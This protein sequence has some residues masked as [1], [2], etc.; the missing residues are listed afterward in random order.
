MILID[1]SALID[2]L[3]EPHRSL[4]TLR[5]LVSAGEEIALASLVFYDWLRGPRTRQQLKDQETI[6]PRERLIAFG[7]SEA[8]VAADLYRVIPRARG[9][10]I[11][12]AIAAIAI[13]HDARL[14]TL[15]RETSAT[16]RVFF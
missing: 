12:I 9:R 16:S 5:E 4:P 8:E 13:S 15:N 10:E 2:S 6:L 1:T 3:C 7:A 14:W 11:E